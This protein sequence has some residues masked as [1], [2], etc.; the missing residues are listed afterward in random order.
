MVVRAEG[1][2]IR[3]VPEQY[4]V[5]AMAPLVVDHQMHAAA[6]RLQLAVNRQ[7][8]GI[9]QA[10]FLASPAELVVGLSEE[11]SALALPTGC[12]VP[13]APRL[14]ITLAIVLALPL[15]A[16]WRATKAE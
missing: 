3:S 11:V 9:Q 10:D 13:F 14:L 2:P 8:T 7:V 12:L 1:L 5:A 16:G 6:V 15:L 4:R